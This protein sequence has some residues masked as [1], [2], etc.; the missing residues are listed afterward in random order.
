MY[1][2][3]WRKF[4]QTKNFPE[5][6]GKALKTSFN[7][8]TKEGEKVKI[9]FAISAVSTEGALKNLNAEVS[10][11]DFNKTRAET[12]AIWNKELSKVKVNASEEKKIAFYTSLYHSFICPVEYM[13]VDG[14]YRGIDHNI[15]EAKGFKNY[16]VFSLWDTF[17]AQ[18]PLLT[19]IQPTRANDMVNSMLAHY[20]QSVHKMLPIW[21]HFGNENWCM[22]GYH[23]VSVISDAWVKG[24]RG[25]DKSKALE[26]CLSSSNYKEYDGIGDYLKYK[27]IPNESSRVGASITLEYAYDDW[28][29]SN[30][31]KSIGDEKLSKE[32]AERSTYWENLFDKS[33]GYIRAKTKA[34]DWVSP[35]DP[36][37]TN[38]AGF[39]EGNSWNYSLYVPHDV[40]GLISAMGGNNKFSKHLD[41]LFTM[42]IPDKYF[43][44][45]EDITR[46]GIMG[47]YV[48]GNEPSHHVPYMYNW[49]G[50]PWKTQER[51]HKILDTKYLNKPNG[52]CGNDDCGQMSAW[53]IFSSLGFYPVCPG[54]DQ[55]VIGSPNLDEAI[56]NLENGKTFT[57]KAKNLSKKNIYIKSATLN[58]KS[59]K[60]CFL[61]H[62]EIVNGGEI[63]F[64]MGRRPNKRW[65][66]KP[67]ERP[68]SSSLLRNK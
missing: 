7:F 58:G 41:S 21:S 1:N 25:F 46:E 5:M 9:K 52:L 32:Y 28:C 48:H 67:S 53:Y 50:K 26:A 47:G 14:K 23:A 31:A 55:Y 2:G 15:H 19:L 30:F 51:I 12:K 44:H 33:T 17:R 6:A 59:L 42:H 43:A 22:I 29:I 66:V 38:A 10:H 61:S 68:F 18:H 49:A 37:E 34:G 40:E 65:G 63:V 56:I 64:K 54:S 8:S 45:H 24:L 60:N 16:S 13:D 20:D 4:N 57:I 39:I 27:Y 3:F 11:F 62:K 36:L 35:F